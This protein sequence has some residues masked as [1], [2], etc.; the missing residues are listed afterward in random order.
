MKRIAIITATIIIFTILV[1]FN[2]L[3]WDNMKKNE[4]LKKSETI[5]IENQDSIEFLLSEINDKNKI[6]D[7]IRQQRSELQTIINDFDEIEIAYKD[8]I[9]KQEKDI[10][11]FYETII[12]K[13]KIINAL[14]ETID[15]EYF[16]EF[17]IKKWANNIN[18]KNYFL[19]YTYQ[20]SRLILGD[21]NEISV[22]AFEEQYKNVINI[23]VVSTEM[24]EINQDSD[25][26][27]DVLQFIVK[28]NIELTKDENELPVEDKYFIEGEN[29]FTFTFDYDLIKSTWIIIGM[30]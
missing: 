10:Q 24:D 21:T 17:L 5:R 8:K 2:Y 1:G 18:T 25:T 30:N 9:S 6:A 4:K 12:L 7:Q 3:L 20:N 23:E 13:N 16:K 27:I 14:K 19:A 26:Q 22:A 28:L 11:D 15:D 29:I